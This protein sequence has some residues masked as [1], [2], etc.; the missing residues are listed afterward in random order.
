M[1]EATGGTEDRILQAA[2]IVADVKRGIKIVAAMCMAGFSAEEI[3]V[4]RLCQQVRRKAKEMVTADTT[5]DAVIPKEISSKRKSSATSVVSSLTS[6]ERAEFN[7]MT[8]SE[9]DVGASIEEGSLPT[10]RRLLDECNSLQVQEGPPTKKSCRSTRDVHA[11]QAET[12]R[13]KKVEATAMKAAT[14]RVQ[15]NNSLPKN[16]P[17]KR[18]IDSI[19][20]EINKLYG[21]NMSPKTVGRHVRDGMIGISPMKKGPTG[22]I[23]RP[24]HTSLK[25]VHATFLQ[26][27]QAES[28]TQSALKQMSLRVNQCVHESG[29]NNKKSDD[30]AKRLKQDMA[31]LFDVNKANV[32]EQRRLQWMT[33]DNMK[34]WHDT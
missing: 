28:K 13:K 21:S 10:P 14:R 16:N 23:P 7:G 24:M 29:N 8:T 33:Y 27:E 5:V 1:S 31:D 34:V 3:K 20:D 4:M 32:M 6:D 18:S 9:E 2:G 25:M 12:A 19:V 15:I 26:L 22:T 17:S 30:L 11:V